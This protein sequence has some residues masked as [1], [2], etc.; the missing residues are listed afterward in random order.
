[1]IEQRIVDS[2]LDTTTIL[3]AVGERVT[4]VVLRQETALPC[5]VY[6][7]L[8]DEPDYTLAGRG[9]WR[10]VTMQISCWSKNYGEIRV[11]AD[12]VRKALDA[13]SETSGSGSIR[14]TSISGAADEYSAEVDAMAAVVLA[15]VEY[16]D[17]AV[18]L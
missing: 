17:E 13:Y 15:T 11:L 18:T 16:D 3:A 1:M 7:R 10:T 4:P 2:L 12:E 6:R 14:F 8:S 9:R 5:L